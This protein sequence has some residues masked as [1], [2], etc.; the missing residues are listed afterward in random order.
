MFLFV[1]GNKVCHYMHAFIT[2]ICNKIYKTLPEYAINC[3]GNL[4]VSVNIE[5]YN[6]ERVT[7]EESF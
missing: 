2:P 4:L 3:V 1:A 6:V 5:M 7:F